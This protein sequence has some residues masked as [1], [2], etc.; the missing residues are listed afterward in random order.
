MTVAKEVTQCG[1]IYVCTAQR[2]MPSIFLPERVHEVYTIPIS[3]TDRKKI[4]A[5][6]IGTSYASGAAVCE[7]L[8]TCLARYVAAGCA[9][10]HRCARRLAGRR[11]SYGC[12]RR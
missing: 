8:P 3:I 1:T 7:E 12:Y 2:L 5:L 9:P 10:A 4:G 11:A 6:R